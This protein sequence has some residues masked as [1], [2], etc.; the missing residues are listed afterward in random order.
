MVAVPFFHVTGCFALLCVA[1]ASGSMIAMMRKWDPEEAFSIIERERITIA[2]GVPTIAW[3][4]LEHPARASY[5]LSSLENITYG[6]APAAPELV[7]RLKEVFPNLDPSTGWGMTETSATFT[8]FYGKDYENRPA[9]CGLPPPI[10][11][12]KVVGEDGQTLPPGEIGELWAR[13]P[14]VVKGYWNKP[15]ASA[16]TFRE[17]WVVTGDMA[18]LDEEGFCFIVDRAKDMIIRGGENIYCTEVEAVLFQH[19]AIMDAALV[20]CPHHSL[21]E[22]PA[23]VV[24]LIPGAAATEADLRDWVAARLAA[25]NTPVK[26]VFWDGPLPRNV[27]GKILK[28]ELKKVFAGS[29]AA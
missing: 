17:G 18:R 11:Q 13:G 26:V 21:G 5:D 7:K 27:N 1:A 16:Q 29:E 22:E 19:P 23:A 4:L 2:G 14:N 10:G 15:E 12:L 8:H 28:T 6:G 20:P 3:Q 9:S 24:T 25:Y